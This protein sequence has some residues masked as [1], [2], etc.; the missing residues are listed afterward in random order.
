[1]IL[2]FQQQLSNAASD[3]ALP[4]MTSSLTPA[5]RAASSIAHSSSKG[6]GAGMENESSDSEEQDLAVARA[7]RVRGM[8]HVGQINKA[9]CRVM[10]SNTICNRG[11]CNT[12]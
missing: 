5:A 6:R 9:K 12:C 11:Y 10:N 1:M 4:V 8:M 3:T 2:S 7:G